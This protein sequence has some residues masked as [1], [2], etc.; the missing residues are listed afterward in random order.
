[1]SRHEDDSKSSGIGQGPAGGAASSPKLPDVVGTGR[2]EATTFARLPQ[3]SSAALMPETEGRLLNALRTQIGQLTIEQADSGIRHEDGQYVVLPNT[4]RSAWLAKVKHP[5]LGDMNFLVGQ[6][7]STWVLLY[8]KPHERIY[9][10]PRF[11]GVELKQ[12]DVTRTP[13][14]KAMYVSRIERTD[15]DKINAIAASDAGERPKS[16]SL[17]PTEGAFSY[18][19]TMSR[20]RLCRLTACTDERFDLSDFVETV[21]FMTPTQSSAGNYYYIDAGD[22][23]DPLA[24]ELHVGRD[25][26]LPVDSYAH[27][28]TLTYRQDPSYLYIDIRYA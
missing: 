11:M 8:D 22:P 20:L 25:P 3:F 26:Q 9:E 1:M 6:T 12:R 2:Q 24:C 19:E 16:D 5:V 7:R 4:L 18:D 15:L 21:H 10:D 28:A 23:E 13:K 17:E 14:G 27:K